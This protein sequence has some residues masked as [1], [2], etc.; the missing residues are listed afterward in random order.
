MLTSNI[1][2]IK[3]LILLTQLLKI[4]LLVLKIKYLVLVI[5]SKKLT[6]TQKKIT[7]H[8]DDKYITAPEFNKL[9]SE[10][11]DVRLKQADLASKSDVANFVNR[12]DLDN[13]VKNVT[14]IKYELN[15]LSKKVKTILTKGL[16]KDKYSIINETKYFSLGIFQNYL[17]FIPAIKSI[18]H[19]HATTRIYSWKSNGIPEKSLEN[20]T[21]ADSNV[22]PT[23]VDHHS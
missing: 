22:A 12:R 17:V 8:N 1:L 2:K 13:Q 21:K 5:S 4:L 7:D 14:S 19:F 15:E 9:T 3:Y 20:I 6:I 16:I 10:N 18:K 11:F 23:F